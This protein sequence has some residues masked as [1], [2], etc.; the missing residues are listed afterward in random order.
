MQ[1]SVGCCLCRSAILRKRNW[2]NSGLSFP[3]LF[4]L[5]F[6]P[7]IVALP[8]VMVHKCPNVCVP[9]SLSQGTTP[10]LI[11]LVQPPAVSYVSILPDCLAQFIHMIHHVV[12]HESFSSFLLLISLT[13]RISAVTVNSFSLLATVSVASSAGEET[14]YVAV[15]V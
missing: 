11:R 2:K 15:F 6:V 13:E 7:C 5:F 1:C 8:K 14:F 10:D 4:F 3:F 12:F 9:P